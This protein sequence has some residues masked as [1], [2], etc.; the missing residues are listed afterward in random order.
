MLKIDVGPSEP[1]QL[2]PA[3]PTA[4]QEPPS[5]PESVIGVACAALLGRGTTALSS[6]LF[7]HVPTS[8]AGS[9]ATTS[10]W[11]TLIAVSPARRACRPALF[12][13]HRQLRPALCDLCGAVWLHQGQG[14]QLHRF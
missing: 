5:G 7:P 12:R 1:T 6:S 11:N 13:R 2:T 9:P 14:A 10:R 8:P 3:N 4:K